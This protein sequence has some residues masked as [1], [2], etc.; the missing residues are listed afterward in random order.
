MKVKSLI[1]KINKV[2]FIAIT[3]I[4]H[5]VFAE[6]LPKE[7][8]DVINQR[9]TQLSN[10]IAL[11]LDA[12]SGSFDED[13][14]LFLI[15]NRIPT[16]IFAT[17]KWLLKNPKGVSLLK[18]H[19][20]LFDIEDHGENHI[21]AVIGNGRKVYGIPGE[22]DIL[23]LQ[24]EVIEGA[25]AVQNITGVPPHWYRGATAEYDQK[26][27]DEIRRMGYKIAGFSVNA[28]EGATLKTKQITERLSHVHGGDVIIAHMN[29]PRSD[30]A[31]GLS[32][33]IIDILKK[34]LVFVR[35]DQVDLIEIK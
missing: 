14:I 12:C 33:G 10:R 25:H 21:P 22:P 5:Q 35:L 13:L 23:H 18:A 34:G 1:L 8:H 29:K 16:T 27:S 11:T 31:E 24:R 28:D 32:S 15:R 26:A 19:L 3:L 20:D 7:I 6:N 9:S 30:T 2:I 17:E 4:N